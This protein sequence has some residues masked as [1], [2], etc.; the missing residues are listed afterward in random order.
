[1]EELIT[2]ENKKK[3]IERVILTAESIQRLNAWLEQIRQS[4]PGVEITRKNIVNWLILSHSERLSQSEEKELAETYYNELRFL[5]FAVRELKAANERGDTL[6]FQ[7]FI[8]KMPTLQRNTVGRRKT[9]KEKIELN[10]I[11]LNDIEK[12]ANR[13]VRS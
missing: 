1:M 7:D 11:D 3:E 4:R 6:S 5:Q 8:D 9:F 10:E 12:G 13:E 2:Q